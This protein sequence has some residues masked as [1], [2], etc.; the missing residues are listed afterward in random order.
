MWILFIAA[1]LAVVIYF[2]L[3]CPSLG[4]KSGFFKKHKRFAHRGLWGGALPENSMAAFSLAAEKGYGIELDVHTTLDGVAV[5]HHDDSLKRI[6]GVDKS[7]EKSEYAEISG[8]TLPNGEVLPLFSD[9][10]GLV[11]GRVPIMIELKCEK[12]DVRVADVALKC[13][14]GYEG[15]ICIESFDPIVCRRAKKLAPRVPCGQLAGRT[16]AEGDSAKRKMIKFI[17]ERLLFNFISRPDFVSYQISNRSNISFRLCRLIGANVSFWTV[18]N[19][20]EL[21]ICDQKG[22]AAIFEGIEA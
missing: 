6:C 4:K 14:E 16:Y 8:V 22:A 10:L 9:V 21:K 11:S 15:E 20:D 1:A 19:S 13:L 2:F 18:R 7:I 17:A 5:V 12:T 3:I